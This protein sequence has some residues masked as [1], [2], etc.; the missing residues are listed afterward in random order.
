MTTQLYMKV[1]Q[2][3]TIDNIQNVRKQKKHD[4]DISKHLVCVKSL[5]ILLLFIIMMK[6]GRRTFNKLRKDFAEE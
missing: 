3:Q 2:H 6:I 1:L 4:E 5:E